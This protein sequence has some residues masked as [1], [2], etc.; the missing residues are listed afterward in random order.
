M[1]RI[2]SYPQGCPLTIS[3]KRG[4]KMARISAE[5]IREYISEKE[6][7]LTEDE[8]LLLYI[9]EL[10]RAAGSVAESNDVNRRPVMVRKAVRALYIR[11]YTAGLFRSIAIDRP[12]KP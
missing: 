9:G 1:D 7:E 6:N 4:V 5:E 2:N 10:C 3:T 11:A 8:A 12:D